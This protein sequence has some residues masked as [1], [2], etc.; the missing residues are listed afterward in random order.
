M[1]IAE[2]PGEL[3]SRPVKA[4]ELPEPPVR[5]GNLHSQIRECQGKNVVEGSNGDSETCLWRVKDG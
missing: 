1:Y 2:G 3:N 4:A 5:G